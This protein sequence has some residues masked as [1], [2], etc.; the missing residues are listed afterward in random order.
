M[1]VPEFCGPER[2]YP[3]ANFRIHRE[4]PDA[5]NIFGYSQ[6]ERIFLVFAETTEFSGSHGKEISGCELSGSS[7][8][9]QFRLE[10]LD[11]VNICGSSGYFWT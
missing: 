11:P 3:D 7:G 8:N 9:F 5:V 6:D 1:S 10:F 2:M 4:F